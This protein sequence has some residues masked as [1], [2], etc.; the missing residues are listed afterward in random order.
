M[1]DILFPAGRMIGGSVDKLFEQKENGKPKL[2]AN[3]QPVMKCSIG[4]AI[5]KG[6]EKHWSETPWG[7]TIYQTGAAAHPNMVANPAFSWKITDGDSK[8]GRA[9]V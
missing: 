3:G 4:V 6:A 7:A 8:I 5:P 9:H 2:D 1:A